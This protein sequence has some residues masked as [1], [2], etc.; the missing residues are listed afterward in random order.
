EAIPDDW[1]VD[2]ATGYES[3]ARIDHALAAPDGV[4]TILEHERRR[5]G[6]P[7]A[8]HDLTLRTKAQALRDLFTSERR[9]LRRRFL[10]LLNEL[11][12]PADATL[13]DCARALE[14]ITIAL[15]RYR[16]YIS[17]GGASASDRSTLVDA[18]DVARRKSPRLPAAAFAAVQ[19]I[20]L[21]DDLPADP[22]ARR[23]HLEVIC[24]WQQLSGPLAAKGVEDTA[25]YVDTSFIA[26]NE[27]GA[28]PTQIDEDAVAALHAFFQDRA[29]T[30]P[31]ALSALTTHDSKRSADIRA[32]LLA[33]ADMPDEWLQLLSEFR[34]ALAAINGASLDPAEESLLLQTIVGAWPLDPM[35]LDAFPD[36]V[37]RF[38]IKAAREAK[39][40]TSWIDGNE[41]H[42]AALD[43]AARAVIDDI[44]RGERLDSIR[45]CIDRIAHAGALNALSALIISAAAPGAPDIYQGTER[46]RFMLVDPDN[47][48][49]VDFAAAAEQLRSIDR[50]LDSNPG[51]AIR[52]LLDAW[53]DGGLKQFVTSR[54]LR[55]RHDH[56]DLFTIGEH[57]PL[58]A[59]GRRADHLIAFARRLNGR[60]AIAIAPRG[61]LP[62]TSAQQFPLGE[63][64]WDD[65]IIPLPADAPSRWRC[66][67]TGHSIDSRSMNGDPV[68][69]AA[70]ALAALPV[71]LLIG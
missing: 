35:S 4:T 8:F 2:G 64:A 62:L 46:W 47:R 20:L 69:G 14:A 70:E 25:L 60:T 53:P 66:A 3:M 12:P 44:R 27:V 19:R 40:R 54:L 61:A 17:E 67:L 37:S 38:M 71:A 32:R 50:E 23:R 59:R 6:L 51:D 39:R 34:N 21:L 15:P 55:A 68:I 36:R 56:P 58:T 63:S 5:A 26:L 22:G 52:A 24:R 10:A 42:E 43:H 41:T 18:I 9:A 1:P 28:E 49:P 7:G 13:R 11:P 30:H 16:T 29:A 65:T 45:E 48:G 57:L 31:R 33:L